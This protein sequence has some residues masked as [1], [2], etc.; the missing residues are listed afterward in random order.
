MEFRGAFASQGRVRL[1]SDDQARQTY[2]YMASAVFTGAKLV[3]GQSTDHESTLHP[4][5]IDLDVDATNSV[6][7][8]GDRFRLKLMNEADSP[9]TKLKER[10]TPLDLGAPKSASAKVVMHVGKGVHLVETP[11]AVDVVDPCFHAKRSVRRDATTVTIEDTY[12]ST[13]SQ[14]SAR[15]YTRYRE[16]SERARSLFDAA[17]VFDKVGAKKT[18]AR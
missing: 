10:Q 1:R 6:T 17:I 3:S 13:C 7:H 8:E 9:A 4:L 12:E 5:A 11:T 14:V 18:P 2:D 15:D 16:N